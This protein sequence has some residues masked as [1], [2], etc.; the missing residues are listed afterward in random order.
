M[1]TTSQK[2]KSISS[3]EKT[4]KKALAVIKPEQAVEAVEVSSYMPAVKHTPDQ[5]IA[6][7]IE[8]GMTIDV[9]ERLSALQKEWLDRQ[10][11][12]AF[13]QS[14]TDFQSEVP[15]IPKGRKVEFESKKDTTR[16][17]KYNYAELDKIDAI[18][19]PFK[20]KFGLSTDWKYE[21]FKGDDGKPMIRVTCVVSHVGGHSESTTMEGEHDDS[22]LKNSIQQRGSTITFLQRYTLIGALGL[23]TANTDNDG[24]T[25]AD[26]QPEKEKVKGTVDKPEMS[27]EQFNKAIV[28]INKGE[29]IL[30]TCKAQFTLTEKQKAGLDAADE[31]RIAK[32]NKKEEEKTNS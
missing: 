21:H 25:Y 14:M 20:K 4:K 29:D 17:V 18:I 27:V 3:S 22:G 12:S 32:A 15:V 26:R 31:A 30:A 24:R 6:M 8:K 10:A 9:L 2:K 7:G 28:R 13:L 19:K 23:T 16:T 5:L 11:K 1:S